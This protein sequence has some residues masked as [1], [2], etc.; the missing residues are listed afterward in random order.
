MIIQVKQAVQ[1]MPNQELKHRKSLLLTYCLS[2]MILVLLEA[3]A[4]QQGCGLG[5]FG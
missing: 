3:E 1:E 5:H 2:Y 4:L